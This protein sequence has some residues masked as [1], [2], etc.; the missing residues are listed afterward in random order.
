MSELAIYANYSQ[1]IVAFKSIVCETRITIFIEH[2]KKFK[3]S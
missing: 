2:L 1:T 3:C